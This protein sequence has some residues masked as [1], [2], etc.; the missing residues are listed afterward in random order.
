MDLC[1][2]STGVACTFSFSFS[3]SVCLVCWVSGTKTAATIVLDDR[4]YQIVCNALA[5]INPSKANFHVSVE[6][7]VDGMDGYCTNGNKRVSF[8]SAHEGNK[9]M[10]SNRV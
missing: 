3:P 5:R 1:S 10:S 7:D 4:E 2:K 8:F 6:L 9:L